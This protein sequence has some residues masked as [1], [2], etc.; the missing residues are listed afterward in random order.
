MPS[1]VHRPSM[2]ARVCNPNI[3]RGERQIP[4]LTGQPLAERVSFW[5]SETM[6]QSGKA[7][8]DR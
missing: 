1:V 8:S 3:S 4:R 6:F 2:A 5:S 7:E